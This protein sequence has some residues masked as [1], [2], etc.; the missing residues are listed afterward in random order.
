[1]ELDHFSS[2]EVDQ[3]VMMVVVSDLKSAARVAKIMPPY[4][5]LFFQ[6]F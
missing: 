6:R 3:M 4:Q 2:L 1:M 5:A